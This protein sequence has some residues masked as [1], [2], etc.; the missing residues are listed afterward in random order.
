MNKVIEISESTRAVVDKQTGVVQIHKK[1]VTGQIATV[2]I[3]KTD[4]IK[5]T[6]ELEK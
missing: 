2:F 5:L 3:N 4:L 1:T 6:K